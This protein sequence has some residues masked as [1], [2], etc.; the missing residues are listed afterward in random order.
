MM[1]HRP[2]TSKQGVVTILREELVG[3][4]LKWYEVPGVRLHAHYEQQ[5]TLVALGQVA[6]R[7]L[8]LDQSSGGPKARQFAPFPEPTAS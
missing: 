1:H 5:S 2:L 4:H 3:M 6:R 8:L 7:L